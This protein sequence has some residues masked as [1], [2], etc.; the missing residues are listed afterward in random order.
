MNEIS[1]LVFCSSLGGGVGKQ[2]VERGY[3]VY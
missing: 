1:V 3:F 2:W